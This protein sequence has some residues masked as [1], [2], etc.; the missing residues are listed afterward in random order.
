MPVQ[1]LRLFYGK[2]FVEDVLAAVVVLHLRRGIVPVGRG[3]GRVI[4]HLQAHGTCPGCDSGIVMLIR[5]HEDRGRCR[6]NAERSH[7]LIAATDVRFKFFPRNQEGIPFLPG[8]VQQVPVTVAADIVSVGK[9]V[10]HHRRI[11]FKEL[12]RKEERAFDAE[13]F[14]RSADGSGTIG[15]VMRGKHQRDALAGRVHAH[16][17]AL[18]HDSL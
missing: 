18:V 5:R 15:L 2:D 4:H 9:E 14:E 8:R 13:T 10:F 11:G 7:H 17:A 16:D 12:S 3:A 6:R 1:A